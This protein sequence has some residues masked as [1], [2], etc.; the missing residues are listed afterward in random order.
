MG[1]D[2]RERKAI[3]KYLKLNGLNVFP[4]NFNKKYKPT[5]ILVH[6]DNACGLNYVFYENK[7]MYFPKDWDK[8]R[9]QYYYTSLLVEQDISS[10][11]RYASSSFQVQ[12][13]DV[14]LDCGTAEGNFALSVVEKA[15]KLYLFEIE[16]EWLTALEKTFAP[17]KDKVVIVNKYIS[18]N[19]DNNCITLDN[20]FPTE[21]INFLKADIEGAELQLLNGAKSLLARSTKLRVV[22]CTYHKQGDAELFDRILTAKGF[23]TEFSAGYMLVY[24]LPNFAPP[25]LRRGVIRATKLS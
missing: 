1:Q 5:N 4:Y 25:Y 7:K 21:K 12:N 8:Q 13:N 6:Y 16:K 18:D 23:K 14:V 17:W 20:L 22:L 19:S 11:H 15:Q 3:I 24:V 9:I 2:L 10:P